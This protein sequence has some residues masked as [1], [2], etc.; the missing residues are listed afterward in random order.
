MTA[1]EVA[2][3]AYDLWAKGDVDG[4]AELF[5]GGAVF[6][7]PGETRVSGVHQGDALR[8][9]LSELAAAAATGVNRQELVC[10]Y[11]SESGAMFVFDN[12]ITLDGRD[13]KY[14]SAHE[15]IV[16][17]GRLV[18]LMVY[19]HEYDLFARVWA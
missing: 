5:V 19:V 11:E 17:D 15:W 1:L 10:K 2:A 13:E 7:V 8:N 4:L 12:F 6:V 9:V 14:H 16:R 18:A 3:S